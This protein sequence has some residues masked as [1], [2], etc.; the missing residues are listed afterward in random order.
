MLLDVVTGFPGCMHDAWVLQH[1]VLFRMARKG[2]ILSKPFDQIN[3]VTIKPVLLG[4]GVCQKCMLQQFTWYIFLYDNFLALTQMEIT[5]ERANNVVKHILK[6]HPDELNQL[7]QC[8]AENAKIMQYATLFP[9]YY[10]RSN[11]FGIQSTSL[12]D[13]AYREWIFNIKNKP[14]VAKDPKNYNRPERNLEAKKAKEQM[15]LK[16]KR[17]SKNLANEKANLEKRIKTNNEE[18]EKIKYAE[19]YFLV[20]CK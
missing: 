7:K 14:Q 12:V 9:K 15:N 6:E 4:D 1:T 17:K 8:L 13:L 11:K 3:S 16:Q 20:Y 2:E 5:Y 19:K 10:S 18:M